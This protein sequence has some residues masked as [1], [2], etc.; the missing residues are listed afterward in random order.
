[1]SIFPHESLRK[2][3]CKLKSFYRYL[4]RHSMY[5]QL[6]MCWPEN[7]FFRRS[8][9]RGKKAI[10]KPLFRAFITIAILCLQY[11]NFIDVCGPKIQSIRWV[12]TFS[13][14]MQVPHCVTFWIAYLGLVNQRKLFKMHSNA[15]NTCLNGK[16]KYTI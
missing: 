13:F 4:H 12:A 9:S 11:Y 7:R 14:L 16:C 2:L 15:E 6:P 5:R 3:V 1:M 10:S 8:A